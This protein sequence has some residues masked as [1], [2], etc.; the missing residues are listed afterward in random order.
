MQSQTIA[1]L[2]QESVAQACAKGPEAVW[3]LVSAV[4]E[5]QQAIIEQLTARIAEL[6]RRLGKNSSNSSKPPSSDGLKRTT[7]LRTNLTG[8]KPGG[9]PGH[10]GH[11]LRQSSRP[12]EIIEVPLSRCPQCAAALDAEPALAPELRQVFD[13]PP[14]RFLVTEYRAQRKM[15]P[16]CGQVRRASFP[17]GVEA[18]VQ[19]GA[20]FNAVMTQFHAGHF[21][22][23]ARVGEV[24]EEL[25]GH[26]PSDAAV[27][28]SLH[29]SAAMMKPTVEA[30]AEA[31]VRER[32]VHAD[33]TG[34]R[35]EKKTQWIHVCSTAKLTHLSRSEHRGVQAFAQADI[36]PRYQGRLVHDFWA[37]Y[38]TLGCGHGYCNAH[39]LRELKSMKE[40][41][42]HRWAGTLSAVLVEMKDAA[43]QAR[44]SARSEV[45]EA[46]RKNLRQRYDQAVAAALLA[47][48]RQQKRVAGRRGGR[49]KQSLEHCLLAR[50]QSEAD[51]VLRFLYELDVPF[52][53]NQAERDLR[54]IKVQQK[55]SGCFR[56]NAAAEAFC[57]VRGYLSTAKKHGLGMLEA[58]LQAL[59]SSPFSLPNTT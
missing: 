21:I 12:D 23:C 36:L 3:Q 53:N 47:H 41:H 30:I 8:R 46:P 16:G 40:Q 35:S 57:I 5:A 18:P 49:I 51:N 9:Q 44:Q 45:P 13:L 33:E 37:P 11:T 50:L 24:C 20:R 34:V 54:M 27:M 58:I 39:L 17:P 52:D 32:V 28:G 55:V 25:F 42:G 56:S 6:E 48:P 15:C 31:L 7:S 4:V 1:I 2:T 59:F 38:K 43:E 19:Y 14:P 26:R 10:P 29:Q 22:P